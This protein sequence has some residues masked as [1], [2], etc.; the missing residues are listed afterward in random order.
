MPSW[1]YGKEI[2]TERTS[3]G[4]TGLRDTF[5]LPRGVIAAVTTGGVFPGPP[6]DPV[7]ADTQDREAFCGVLIPRLLGFDSQH[8]DRGSPG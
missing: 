7:E 4:L 8:H 1:C 6:Q 3:N 2:N 5:P